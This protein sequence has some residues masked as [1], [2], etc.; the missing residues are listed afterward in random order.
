MNIIKKLDTYDDKYIYFCEPIKNNIMNDGTFIRILYSTPIFALN[1]V[2]LLIHLNSVTIEKCYNKYKYMFNVNAHKEMI[3]RVR[4]IEE[5]LL[6]KINIRNKVPQFKIYEQLQNGNIKIFS[7]KAQNNVSNTFLLKIS[8][9]WE[10]ETQYGVT[11]KFS[12]IS[13]L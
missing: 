5:N 7:D 4:V 11:Y 12:K 6:Q 3:E 10:T 2:Y 8:G 13:H 1:G 9:I